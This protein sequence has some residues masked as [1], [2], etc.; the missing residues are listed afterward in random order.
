MKV[1]DSGMPDEKIWEGF[2]D[3]KGGIAS[4]GS[5]RFLQGWMDRY[6][7]WVKQHTK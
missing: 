4:E 6:V 3:A 2:F 5:K 1:R 7:A